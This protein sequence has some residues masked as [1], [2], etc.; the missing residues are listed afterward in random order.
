MSFFRSL[1]SNFDR[2]VFYTWKVMKKPQGRAPVFILEA[3]ETISKAFSVLF[4]EAFETISGI[5]SV[6][7]VEVFET[8]LEPLGVLY[9][10]GYEKLQ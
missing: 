1:C 4:L 5:P 7:F 8:T 10:E 9:F 6:L 2:L 3:F